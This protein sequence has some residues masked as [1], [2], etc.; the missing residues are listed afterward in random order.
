MFTRFSLIL[1]A[2]TLA[3]CGKESDDS[4]PPQAPLPVPQG[5][6]VSDF[7][8]IVA[9][10]DTGFDLSHPIFKNK[11]VSSQ[12]LKCPNGKGSVF[13]AEA[14]SSNRWAGSLKDLVQFKKGVEPLPRTLTGESIQ[15]FLPQSTSE[16]EKM[17]KD[18][19]AS[20]SKDDGCSVAK[21]IEFPFDP[22]LQDW[23]PLRE[24]WNQAILSKGEKKIR[25]ERTQ[26]VELVKVLSGQKGN[27][28]HGT[29]TA[30]LIAHN[31]PQTG[32]LLVQTPL[33]EPGDESIGSCPNDAE[34][35]I[36]ADL[37]QDPEVQTAY[38]ASPQT[39]AQL[40]I[41]QIFR[42]SKVSI[43]NFSAGPTSYLQMQ[44][45]LKDAGC[46]ADNLLRFYEAFLEVSNKR[47]VALT[48]SGLTAE[49]IFVQAAGNDG[50][51]VEAP[52][53]GACQDVKSGRFLVGSVNYQ[54]KTS[55]FTNSGACVSLSTLGEAVIRPAP[56]GFYTVSDGTSFAA[57][58]FARW[59]SMQSAQSYADLK[60]IAQDQMT[61]NKGVLVDSSAM[62]LA[63]EDK[64]R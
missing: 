48:E 42:D 5:K 63:F 41:Q 44:K 9:V 27:N 30:G 11:V 1:V 49:A 13:A 24:E 29:G 14:W 25:M 8:R 37:F 4:P 56:A 45:N 43:V 28:P 62:G 54:G 46:R 19:I 16:Y 52:N 35:A 33:G 39:K 21:G 64:S 10:V 53:R 36:V 12:S 20:F 57:P 38:I 7:A 18:L 58:L 59:L 26:F 61:L 17:K 22:R 60:K 55:E 32:L 51:P 34:Y 23:I 15:E 47:D 6:K 3:A 50:Q 2:L 40:K 31:N